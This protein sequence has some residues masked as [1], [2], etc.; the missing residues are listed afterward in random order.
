MQ[1]LL[2]DGFSTDADG[3]ISCSGNSAAIT[4]E[5]VQ[6]S[7]ASTGLTKEQ[8]DALL[9]ASILVLVIAFIFALLLRQ[10]R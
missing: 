3:G 9:G 10:L 7:P 4:L 1:L 2:C 8:A 6:A 5:E